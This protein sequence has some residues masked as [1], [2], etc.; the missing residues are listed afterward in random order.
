MLPLVALQLPIRILAS[1]L[2]GYIYLL[3]IFVTLLTN[4][5]GINS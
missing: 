3:P 5:E 4:G 1:D 2:Q